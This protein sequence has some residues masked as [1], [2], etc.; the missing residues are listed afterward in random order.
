MAIVLPK[1]RLSMLKS[2]NSLGHSLM[3]TRLKSTASHSPKLW[4]PSMSWWISLALSVEPI[5]YALTMAFVT[6][7]DEDSLMVL[8]VG[9]LIELKP[10]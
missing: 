3:S 7:E 8:Q 2:L 5:D 9:S 1:L 6:G 4:V 10:E